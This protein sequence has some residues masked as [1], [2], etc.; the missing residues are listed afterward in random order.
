MFRRHLNPSVI[1]AAELPRPN[2]LLLGAVCWMRA[3]AGAEGVS[4]SPLPPAE[5]PSTP[6]SSGISRWDYV[7]SRAVGC[8]FGMLFVENRNSRSILQSPAG[9][10]VSGAGGG[11]DVDTSAVRR[12]KSAVAAR[13]DRSPAQQQRSKSYHR[14][15]ST[16]IEILPSRLSPPLQNLRGSPASRGLGYGPG[17]DYG[18][19]SATTSPSISPQRQRPR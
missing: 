4:L 19:G 2:L 13:A 8:S 3:L 5:H 12:N 1:T 9:W 14:I 18:G 10:G 7:F 17:P 6:I 15:S 11:R 16:P